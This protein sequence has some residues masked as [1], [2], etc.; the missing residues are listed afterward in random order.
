MKQIKCLIASVKSYTDM[1]NIYDNPYSLC[2]LKNKVSNKKRKVAALHVDEEA[3]EGAS[4]AAAAELLAAETLLATQVD[5]NSHLPIAT[6]VQRAKDDFNNLYIQ[7]NKISL[8]YFVL[9]DNDDYLNLI[10]EET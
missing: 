4:A 10:K 3:N 9:N 2:C 5:A 1:K 8:L 7:F 6:R